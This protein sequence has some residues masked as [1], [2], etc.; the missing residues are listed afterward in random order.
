MRG[1]SQ[2]TIHEGATSSIL[3]EDGSADV[4]EIQALSATTEVKAVPLTEFTFE[5]LVSHFSELADQFAKSMSENLF[6]TVSK[7]AD[8]VGNVVDGKGKPLSDELLLE[9]FE[10]IQ[11]DFNPDGTWNPPTIVVSPQQYERLIAEQ[12]P[13]KKLKFDKKLQEIV[14]RKRREH[15]SREAGRVL[16]G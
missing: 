2:R 14:E 5:T 10:T 12:T 3:R 16:A 9:A 8:A 7:A 11:L 4:T 6:A 1:I 15:F 13:A